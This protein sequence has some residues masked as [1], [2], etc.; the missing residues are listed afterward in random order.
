MNHHER[1]EPGERGDSPFCGTGELCS[2]TAVA[3]ETFLPLSVGRADYSPLQLMLSFLFGGGV[4]TL[5]LLGTWMPAY[6]G[7]TLHREQ[8]RCLPRPVPSAR[9]G[10]RGGQ[11]QCP[12]L[13]GT[14]SPAH[15]PD[16]EWCSLHASCCPLGLRN[17]NWEFLTS[18]SSTW[19][20]GLFVFFFSGTELA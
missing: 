11:G 16:A 6:K 17:L 2:Q 9:T 3:I 7:P 20:R 1:K 4:T 5:E 19:G 8:A 18:A 13:A 14:L 12:A 10:N 15:T